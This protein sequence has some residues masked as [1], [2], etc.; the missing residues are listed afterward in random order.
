M[1]KIIGSDGKEYGPVS[2]DRIQQWVAEGRVNA[3]TQVRA[4]GSEEWMK[5]AELPEISSML[6]TRSGAPEPLSAAPPGGS[7]APQNRLAVASLV[8]GILSIVTCVVSGIPAVICGHV[9]LN[10]ARREPHR[11]GG[12]G[13]AL[14]GLILGYVSLVVLPLVILPAMLLP[15]LSHAKGR[16][17]SIN[18]INNMKQIGLAYRIWALDHGDEFPFNVSTN[19]GGTLELCAMGQDGFDSNPA[20]H[21]QVI[22]NELS[23]PKILVCAADTKKQPAFTFVNLQPANITYQ[24]RTGTN[25]NENNP[26]GVLVVCPIHG[27]VLRCD[28]SV[29]AG[30]NGRR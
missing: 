3:R 30:R 27:H 9:A 10:R 24:V 22:S 17:E 23:T 7:A 5:A 15:A 2:L 14:A 4:A 6:A 11:Y 29:Q 8:L 1:Y 28:G 16:A 21:F 26:Q 12:P 25:I 20:L 18:C 13:M 19:R